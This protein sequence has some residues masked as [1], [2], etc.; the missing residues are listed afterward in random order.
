MRLPLALLLL[1][2]APWARA[3]DARMEVLSKQ[4]ASARDPRVRVNAAMG[5]GA[6]GIPGGTAP[7]CSALHDPEPL[8]R[9]AAARA[10]EELQ[11]AGALPCL[12]ARKAE[13]DAD[14]RLALE[15]AIASLDKPGALY[16]ALE[17]VQDE[18]GKLSPEEVR[19]AE[20]L[21]QGE[22]TRL[23]A[24]FAP[25]GES[26]AAAQTMLRGGRRRGY[27]LKPKLLAPEGGL[28]EMRVMVLTYP[29]QAIK[30]THK[31][32]AR[33]GKAASLLKAMVPRVV[34]DMAQ[35]H[36]WKQL[37]PEGSP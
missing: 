37:T 13:L 36:E 2:E 12:R 32:K 33:G 5:L 20:S 21:L 8:V 19:L 29:G 10:L 4:L 22:L 28:L 24:S 30:S 18:S 3:S 16:L 6:L 35:E 27:L 31:V 11:D 26:E 15:Q 7:L 1:L 25:R 34:E 17:P 14:V 23:G 9:T